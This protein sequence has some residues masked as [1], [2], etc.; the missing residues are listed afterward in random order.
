VRKILTKSPEHEG[1]GK[2]GRER[3]LAIYLNDHLAGSTLGVE[4]CRRLRSSNREDSELGQPLAELCEEIEA[5]RETLA[6]LMDRLG[7]RRSVVK[8]A[9]AWVAEKLGRFKLNGQL[10]GYSPLSRLAEIEVLAIGITGKMQMWRAL[11]RSLGSSQAGFDFG[12]LAERAIRQRDR[13]EDLHAIAATLALPS[14][15]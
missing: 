8:P 6:R 15:R 14:R 5:D 11:Q 7:I 9:A 1:S 2:A 12:D 4:L 3:L 10:T 13:V